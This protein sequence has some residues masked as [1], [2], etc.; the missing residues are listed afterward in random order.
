MEPLEVI[1]FFR[2][3]FGFVRDR[4]PRLPRQDIPD[5]GFEESFRAACIS[6]LPDWRLSQPREMRFG[7][8]WNTSSGTEHETDII[9]V[10]EKAIVPVEMKNWRAGALTKNEVIVFY[11]KMVDYFTRNPS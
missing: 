6:S 1:G 7:Y 8:E 11:A 2:F 3:G 4:W 5:E 9:A 10:H